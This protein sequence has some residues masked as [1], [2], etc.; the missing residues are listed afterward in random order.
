MARAA[1]DG[2]VSASRIRVEVAY[3][4][5]GRQELV[6]VEL[7]QGA[8]AAQ[9]IEQSEILQRVPGLD[10]SRIGIFGREVAPAQVLRDGDRVEIYRP[11]Q[12]DPKDARRQRA[13]R[14]R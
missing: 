10:A 4:L 6:E 11:L 14:R 2:W 13:A 3:A 7:E 8:T 1:V 5:P 12:I 9:A